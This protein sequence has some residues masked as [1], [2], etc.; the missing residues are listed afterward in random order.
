MTNKFGT[1]KPQKAGVANTSA[2]MRY[3]L[4]EGP[5][6]RVDL[7]TGVGLTQGPITRIV[8]D[9]LERGLVQEAGTALKMGGRGRPRIPIRINRDALHVVS[10]HI[11]V[12]Q[13]TVSRVNL[14][15]GVVKSHSREHHGELKAVIRTI[16]GL[17]EKLMTV[18]VAPVLGIGVTI[19]GWV[20]ARSGTVKR[21]ELLQWNDIELKNL[22][23][24]KLPYPVMVESTVRSHA[25]ADM[26]FGYVSDPSNF[27]H[28]FIGNVIEFASVVDGKVL[29]GVDGFGGNVS[30]WKI[31][32]G[33]GGHGYVLDLLSDFAV[34]A[35]AKREGLLPNDGT[36]D[37]LLKLAGGN[38]SNSLRA[39]RLLIDRSR[40]SANLLTLLAFALGP[41]EI[42][43]SSRG[44]ATKDEISSLKQ[45]FAFQM[46]RYPL[47]KLTV[48]QDWRKAIATGGAAVIIEDAL[49]KH[50]FADNS[51]ECV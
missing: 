20:N 42:V 22:L 9:L 2:V 6:S 31:D 17:C 24:S 39:S 23:A 49:N 37:D 32:D 41:K 40:R 18:N 34:L 12:L 29:D 19:G 43:V 4:R 21:S 8:T 1:H 46:A 13:V 3:L 36:W 47:P 11:G 25:V 28:V 10:V 14:S 27:I 30:N 51:L 33:L 26:L 48:A 15:G 45:A 16:T 35:E 38:S 7:A 50:I 44:I 5:T